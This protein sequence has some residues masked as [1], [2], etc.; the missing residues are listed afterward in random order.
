MSPSDLGVPE[1]MRACFWAQTKLGCVP[2][3]G[4]ACIAAAFVDVARRVQPVPAVL[5]PQRVSEASHVPGPAWPRLS[6]PLTNEKA[7]A[8]L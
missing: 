1:E 3:T 5:T 6:K 8:G 7:P 2:H 4:H